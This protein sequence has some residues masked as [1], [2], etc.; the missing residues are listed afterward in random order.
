MS[1]ASKLDE[2]TP[3]SVWEEQEGLG[4]RLLLTIPFGSSMED[5]RGFISLLG[6][7]S[8]EDAPFPVI[9]F[10][11]GKPVGGA[12][13][14]TI[15]FPNSDLYLDFIDS[16]HCDAYAHFERKIKLINN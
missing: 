14:S 15:I 12:I 1:F 11:V 16:L 3:Q 2:E 5:M 8:F 7:E 13:V 6:E 10:C 4:A 9:T